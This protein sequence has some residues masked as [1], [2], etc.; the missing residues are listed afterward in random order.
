MNSFPTSVVEPFANQF[1]RQIVF[2]EGYA[3]IH[4]SKYSELRYWDLYVEWRGNDSWVVTN[5]FHVSYDEDGK[6]EHE[7]Q[8]SS[9][10]EKYLKKYRFSFAEAVRIAEK[11][12]PTIKVNG[13]TV[14]EWVEKQKEWLNEPELP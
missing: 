12:Q 1:V 11:I 10:T 14:L 8:P 5:M 7:R 3:L 9:R 2:N 6:K 4:P 13:C